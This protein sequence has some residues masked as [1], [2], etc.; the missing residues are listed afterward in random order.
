MTEEVSTVFNRIK[1]PKYRPVTGWN[2]N[3]FPEVCRMSSDRSCPQKTLNV[4]GLCLHKYHNTLYMEQRVSLNRERPGNLYTR[5]VFLYRLLLKQ[6]H[7]AS[8]LRSQACSIDFVRSRFLHSMN[9]PRTLYQLMNIY[10]KVDVKEDRK[11]VVIT[12]STC[13][14]GPLTSAS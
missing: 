2:P 14:P 9:R 10:H 8:A 3:A 11:G 7:A 4:R 6:V 5:P 13:N 12:R 1:M